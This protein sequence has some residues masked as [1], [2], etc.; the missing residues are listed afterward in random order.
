LAAFGSGILAENK[1]SGKDRVFSE[2][3]TISY[4]RWKQL[5]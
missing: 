2:L 5:L 3:G 4:W 1:I